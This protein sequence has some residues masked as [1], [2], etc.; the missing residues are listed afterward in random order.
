ME[1]S[2]I[3]NLPVKDR[4]KISRSKKKYLII[5]Y[6]QTYIL[7]DKPLRWKYYHYKNRGFVIEINKI[8]N[9]L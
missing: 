1:Y 7:S 5:G 2:L 3:K 8:I 6:D 4:F 9:I